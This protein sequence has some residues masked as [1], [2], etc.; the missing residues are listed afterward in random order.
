[1]GAVE[2]DELFGDCEGC[3]LG[4]LGRAPKSEQRGEKAGIWIEPA[5]SLARKL[6]EKID[7]VL[8]YCRCT[9]L[10]QAVLRLLRGPTK[11]ENSVNAP[12]A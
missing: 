8:S 11:T 5:K 4:M 6:K 12:T 9:K 1:M 3:R 10:W 2:P 7:G